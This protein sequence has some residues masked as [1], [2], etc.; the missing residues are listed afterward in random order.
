MTIDWENPSEDMIE[1]RG[2][3]YLNGYRDG[4][5]EG[6]EEGRE[7][8]YKQGYDEGVRESHRIQDGGE[9]ALANLMWEAHNNDSLLGSMLDMIF[10]DGGERR[11]KLGSHNATVKDAMMIYAA[12]RVKM[13]NLLMV[14]EQ[15]RNYLINEGLAT[16]RGLRRMLEED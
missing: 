11:K 2:M 8:G 4:E 6:Y 13:G 7:D 1:A 15:C 10:R 3:G 5:I 14:V 12:S 9:D 16:E